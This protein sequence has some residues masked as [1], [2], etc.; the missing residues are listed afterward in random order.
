M[1]Q[2]NEYGRGVPQD[3][4]IAYAL[5]NLAAVETTTQGAKNRD[6]AAGKL[7]P[8]KIFTGQRL[9]VAACNRKHPGLQSALFSA[10]IKC[11]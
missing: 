7:T 9:T 10:Q 1:F 3:W 11:D 8:A 2:S 4:V 6:I 5:F